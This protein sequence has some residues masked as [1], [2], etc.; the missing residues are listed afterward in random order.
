MA[1]TVNLYAWISAGYT[2]CSVVCGEGYK[3]SIIHCQN[4]RTGDYVDEIH[5]IDLTKPPIKTVICRSPRR[6]P[7]IWKAYQPDNSSSCSSTCI[8]GII[9]R[10]VECMYT[11]RINFDEVAP[12]HRCNSTFRPSNVIPCNENVPCRPEWLA[13]SWSECSTTCGPGV[14]HRLILCSVRTSHFDSKIIDNKI[15]AESIAG[16]SPPTSQECI[17]R[18]CTPLKV[19][20]FDHLLILLEKR[21]ISIKAGTNIILFP[22]SSL[23]IFC[24]TSKNVKWKK[25]NETI[26]RSASVKIPH[27][28]LLHITDVGRTHAGRYV[29]GRPKENYTTTLYVHSEADIVAGD[30]GLLPPDD[31]QSIIANTKELFDDVYRSTVTFFKLLRHQHSA[32]LPIRYVTSVWSGCSLPCGGHGVQSRDIQCAV[33]LESFML[34]IHEDYCIEGDQM[35]PMESQDC[36]FHECP[37]WF[38]GEWSQCPSETCNETAAV[39]RNRSVTCQYTNATLAPDDMCQ[40]RKPHSEEICKQVPCKPQWRILSW[41]KCYGKCWKKGF[42]IASL[43]CFS[44]EAKVKERDCYSVERPPITMSCVR[45]CDICDN[46]SKR[47]HNVLKM[48]LCKY[49][50][51][52]RECCFTCLYSH[53]FH[54]QVEVHR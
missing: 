38:V 49:E 52:M 24:P 18:S 35:K 44:G 51:V 21:D 45:K 53:L 23:K 9:S 16:E 11:D 54:N 25:D 43:A 28:P 32:E 10:R 29:C 2:N 20:P 1:Q 3:D 39:S 22:G 37:I 15:C 19:R 8:G 42:R 12:R 30:F 5:C 26:T 14:Q 40:G 41:S 34:T 13:R 47:C 33:V 7:P 48:K 50:S 17:T 27:P 6:C 31:F 4:R 46:L 36:G